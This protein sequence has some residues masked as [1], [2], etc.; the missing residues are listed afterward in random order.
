MRFAES[1]DGKKCAKSVAGHDG[2]QVIWKGLILA[3]RSPPLVEPGQEPAKLCNLNHFP[4]RKCISGNADKSRQNII[5]IL[6]QRR[7]RESRPYP[8]PYG[9][10]FLNS[11]AFIMDSW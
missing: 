8:L 4:A 3:Y 10:G 2:G 11:R 1:R 7:I 6:A 9:H 5:F